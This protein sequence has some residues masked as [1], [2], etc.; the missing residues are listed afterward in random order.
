MNP[1]N[2]FY[3]LHAILVGLT[4]LLYVQKWGEIIQLRQYSIYRIVPILWSIVFLLLFNQYYIQA[5]IELVKHPMLLLLSP[6]IY[7]LI[8]LILFPNSNS[9]DRKDKFA[10]LDYY[11]YFRKHNRIIMGLA[12]IGVFLNFTLYWR[13]T[14]TTTSITSYSYDFITQQYNYIIV[15]TLGFAFFVEHKG[16]MCLLAWLLI[17]VLGSLG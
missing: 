2:Y 6:S 10:Y 12:W 15:G 8:G 5:R 7:Y 3:F 9:L 13:T 1:S 14:N 11:E 16:L 17:V 4:I